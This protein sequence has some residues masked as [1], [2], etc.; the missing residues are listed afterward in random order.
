[1]KCFLNA[2]H[3]DKKNP[4]PNSHPTSISL[5]QSTIKSHYPPAGSLR[6]IAHRH[7]VKLPW[8]HH[9]QGGSELLLLSH[10]HRSGKPQSQVCLMFPPYLPSRLPGQPWMFSC[11]TRTQRPG[12]SMD[13]RLGTH[14]QKQNPPPQR[15]AK[16]KGEAAS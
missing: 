8:S 2:S 9:R 15:R 7:P 4:Q 13:S 5:L 11:C 1:M 6:H 14:L 3:C 16:P 12:G 10:Q